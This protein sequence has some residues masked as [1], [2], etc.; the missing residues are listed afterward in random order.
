MVSGAPSYSLASFSGIRRPRREIITHFHLVPTLKTSGGVPL[1]PFHAFTVQTRKTSSLFLPF[2]FYPIVHTG[3]EAQSNFHSIGKA[4]LPQGLSDR[5][6]QLNTHFSS[7]HIS[8]RPY[9][10]RS[11]DTYLLN[12]VWEPSN[13]RRVCETRYVCLS[14]CPSFLMEQ[15]GSH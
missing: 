10:Y 9:I 15:L 12:G 11:I 13:F 14:T 4:A 5:S 8:T 1:L 6:V 7:T 3:S 2:T